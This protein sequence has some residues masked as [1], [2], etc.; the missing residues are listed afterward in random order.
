MHKQIVISGDSQTLE[1][2]A[3]DLVQ[4]DGVIGLSLQRAGSLKPAGDVLSMHVLN[5]TADDVLRRAAEPTQQG[6]VSIALAE[7]S[8]LIDSGKR[9]LIAV[10]DDEALWE[11]MESQLRNHGRISVNY[12]ILMLL[13]G[14][15]TGVAF[16]LDPVEQAI[17]FVGASITSPAFE[18][19][20]KIS[21]G[22]VLRRFSMV[23]HGVTA[24]LAGYA[25][26]IV[27]AA[28]AFGALLLLGECTHEQLIAE[29]IT[30]SLTSWHARSLI[31]SISAAAAGG[32]MVAS[33]RDSY[34]VGP[35]MVLALIP[36]AGLAGASLACGDLS[37][38]GTAS[39]RIGLDG[40][41]VLVLSAAV[42]A[43]KQKSNHQRAIL[44]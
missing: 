13:G 5:G 35:L 40:M 15:I 6:I 8:A 34:V 1:K 4:L 31:P 18:S 3:A 16:T 10:D 36:A 14:V 39:A 27:A 33:L 30:K 29:P 32:L 26:L 21:Q 11:E 24:A 42:F 28:A 2:M 41:F 23:Q 19:L 44:P 20:A 43:W 22:V 38:F 7:T 17:A 9:E 37:L 12:L 25:V